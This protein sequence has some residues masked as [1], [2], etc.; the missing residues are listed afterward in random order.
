MAG[1]A[2][3]VQ[4][5]LVRQR[6]FYSVALDCTQ[7]HSNVSRGLSRSV[8]RY[9]KLEERLTGGRGGGWTINF[10]LATQTP[11]AV[12]VSKALNNNE[13][14]QLNLLKLNLP[15]IVISLVR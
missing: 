5:Q 2:S 15:L 11:P 7:S 10:P 4:S 13:R 8:S 14:G 3:M 1:G 12:V 6:S 9:E